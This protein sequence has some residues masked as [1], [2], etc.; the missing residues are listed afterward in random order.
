M[1]ST[2]RKLYQMFP[3]CFRQDFIILEQVNKLLV[4]NIVRCYQ[5]H[6]LP[7]PVYSIYINS[8][9]TGCIGCVDNVIYQCGRLLELDSFHRNTFS[10]WCLAVRLFSRRLNLTLGCW[11]NI[12]IYIYIYIYIHTIYI[13]IYIFVLI[14][15]IYYLIKFA[16][17]SKRFS[18]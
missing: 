3:S 10:L 9:S 8:I 4:Q 13:H 14:F 15:M 17:T 7:F 12:Y 5:L 16:T 2:V 1:T 11:R 6:Q 18:L